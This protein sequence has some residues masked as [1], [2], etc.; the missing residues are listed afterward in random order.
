MI[1]IITVSKR[2][3]TTKKDYFSPTET[4]YHMKSKPKTWIET[5]GIIWTNLIEAIIQKTSI[6]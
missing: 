1:S 4:A 2:S 6:F 3:I 5:F